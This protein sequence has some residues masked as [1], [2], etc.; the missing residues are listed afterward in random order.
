MHRNLTRWDNHWIGRSVVHRK[1]NR[2]AVARSFETDGVHKTH[3]QVAAQNLEF[4]LDNKIIELETMVAKVP[5][6]C[7][8]DIVNADWEVSDAKV[9]WKEKRWMMIFCRFQLN[10]PCCVGIFPSLSVGP[11]SKVPVRSCRK[12]ISVTQP[13]Q[14]LLIRNTCTVFLSTSTPSMRSIKYCFVLYLVTSF[15]VQGIV[16]KCEYT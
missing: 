7:W 10:L 16:Y 5:S 14:R 9:K 11:I 3:R 8:G 15:I 2:T 1:T 4:Y 6:P 12:H 13:T